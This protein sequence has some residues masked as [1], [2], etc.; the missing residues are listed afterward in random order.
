MDWEGING[1][2]D[3]L[4]YWIDRILWIENDL[5]K[6]DGSANMVGDEGLPLILKQAIIQTNMDDIKQ[7]DDCP[8]F[9]LETIDF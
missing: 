7:I 2:M 5:I 1:Q 4:D 6:E 9:F 8:H 3:W